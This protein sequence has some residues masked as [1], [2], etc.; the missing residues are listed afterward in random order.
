M[1]AAE[2]NETLPSANSTT[3]DSY[4]EYGT[5]RN[6]AVRKY[7]RSDLEALRFVD[8]HEQAKTW[9]QIRQELE[10]RVSQEYDELVEN[11]QK[12]AMKKIEN[13]KLWER[14]NEHAVGK[15]KLTPFLK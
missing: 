9:S 10:C 13:R 6:R 11:D 5:H 15:S 7:T 14:K 1:I 3:V 4:R 8:A 2:M 12:K